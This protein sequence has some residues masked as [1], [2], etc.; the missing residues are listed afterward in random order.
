M[1]LYPSRTPLDRR[2]NWRT[3]ARTNLDQVEA[4]VV[5]DGLG[6]GVGAVHTVE[7]EALGLSVGLEGEELEVRKTRCLLVI[8][9]P[10]FHSIYI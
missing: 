10:A 1:P 9:V 3:R 8:H 6:G 2:V 5:V 4:I 7:G